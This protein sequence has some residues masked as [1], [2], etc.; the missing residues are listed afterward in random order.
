MVILAAS[1][2]LTNF[3]CSINQMLISSGKWGQLNACL[4]EG[5]SLSIQLQV[6][7]SQVAMVHSEQYVMRAQILG[8]TLL[9]LH[10]KNGKESKNS[11]R[12]N[13]YTFATQINTSCRFSLNA[14]KKYARRGPSIFHSL[15]Q[16]VIVDISVVLCLFWAWPRERA[17][18]NTG[19]FLFP[20]LVM[21]QTIM[22]NLTTSRFNV[23]TSRE[24]QLLN[25]SFLTHRQSASVRI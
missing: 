12:N 19:N 16:N 23:N 10:P 18:A 4:K 2:L 7:M 13:A 1:N 17:N 20:D 14:P 6:S 9:K 5:K 8:F 3:S 22:H 15:L 21:K 25:R 11:G 24:N